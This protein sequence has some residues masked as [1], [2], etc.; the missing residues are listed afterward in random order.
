MTVDEAIAIFSSYSPDEKKLFLAQLMYALT[1]IARAE[2]YEAGGEG[3]TD[4]PRARRINEIQ[5]TVS[6][7][8]WALL[9]NDPKRYP[10][11]VLM[12]IIMEQPADP[13]L[14]SLLGETFARLAAQRLT[15]A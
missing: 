13:A 12:K 11:D 3:L 2:T 15:A 10:D 1:I 8:L 9:R 14:G 6:A 4:A 5:H 7:S